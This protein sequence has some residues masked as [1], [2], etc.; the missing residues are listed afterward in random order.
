MSYLPQYYVKKITSLI[1]CQSCR[2]TSSKN[3]INTKDPDEIFLVASEVSK[4]KQVSM[5][6]IQT[7]RE[8]IFKDFLNGINFFGYNSSLVLKVKILIETHEF[9]T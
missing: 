5:N 4:L 7:L 3:C 6:Q 1:N 9:W 8:V 2:I